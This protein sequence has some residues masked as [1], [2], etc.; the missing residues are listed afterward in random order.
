MTKVYN[1][2]VLDTD[3][4]KP[5]FEDDKAKWWLVEVSPSKRYY[6]YVVYSILQKEKNYMIVDNKKQSVISISKRLEDIATEMDILDRSVK[7]GWL[8]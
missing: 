6:L 2:L 5:T 8:K 7:L 1:P 3:K 4:D